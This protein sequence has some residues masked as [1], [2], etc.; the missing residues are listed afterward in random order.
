MFKQYR[1]LSNILKQFILTNKFQQ[2]DT[3]N[4]EIRSCSLNELGAEECPSNCA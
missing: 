1:H 4:R 2:V 3:Q